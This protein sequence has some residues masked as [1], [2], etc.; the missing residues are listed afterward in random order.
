MDIARIVLETDLRCNFQGLTEI[1]RKEDY[2]L[3]DKDVKFVLFFNKAKTKFKML[4]GPHYLIYFNNGSKRI[5][6]N[7]IT[8]IPSYFNGKTLNV[9]GAIEK[10]VK[11]QLAYLN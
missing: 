8:H 10:T 2:T 4:I 11:E 9:R 7:A 6:M 5:P 3:Q 1:M